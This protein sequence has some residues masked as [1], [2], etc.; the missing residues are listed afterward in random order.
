MREPCSRLGEAG[1]RRDSTERP[2][3]LWT[4]SPGVTATRQ[5]SAPPSGNRGRSVDAVRN[6]ASRRH[7]GAATR[8]APRSGL[9]SSEPPAAEPPPGWDTSPRFETPSGGLSTDPPPT[10]LRRCGDA[11]K[12]SDM[13]EKPTDEITSDAQI[14]RVSALAALFGADGP[15]DLD[16]LT[17]PFRW[18]NLSAK[19][20]R[21]AWPDLRRWVERLVARFP[22]LD[23]HAIPT[24]WWRHNGHVEALTALRDHE[25]VS[26]AATS[27]AT[28][29]V[30][31]HRALRDVEAMLREWT[32]QLGCGA[33]HSDRERQLRRPDDDVWDQFVHADLSR[34]RQAEVAGALDAE[35]PE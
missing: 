7:P 29:A 11:G 23:H 27:Q 34:R 22:H 24:C 20:A 31:W 19:E 17:G 10:S 4:A 3:R 16:D 33:S 28:A 14:E 30:E 26:Y 2:R 5:G 18:A 21:A 15:P 9:D 6:K 8:S 25:R 32:G 35:E 12:D 1:G 13:P